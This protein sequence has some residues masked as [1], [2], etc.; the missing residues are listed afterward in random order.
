MPRRPLSR[1]IGP[2]VA[3]E[4]SRVR[5]TA[6]GGQAAIGTRVAS[7]EITTSAPRDAVAETSM[8]GRTAEAAVHSR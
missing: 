7:R 6:C 3:T 5:P 1:E 4:P 2:E 8:A